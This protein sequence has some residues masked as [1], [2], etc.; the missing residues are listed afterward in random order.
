V[1]PQYSIWLLAM[2][3]DKD[4]TRKYYIN[5]TG[6]SRKADHSECNVTVMQD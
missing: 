4:T 2:S 1:D 5:N 6:A 3:L